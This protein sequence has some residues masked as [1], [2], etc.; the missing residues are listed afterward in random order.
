VVLQ[1]V[2]FNDAERCGIKVRLTGHL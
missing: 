1:E 2:A